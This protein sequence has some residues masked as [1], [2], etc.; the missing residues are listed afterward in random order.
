MYNRVSIK[1]P[2]IKWETKF[3]TGYKRIDDQHKE[4]VN[5][6]NDLYETGVVGDLSNEYVRRSF[7]AIIKRT[8]DYATYHF[9][10]E[11]KIMKAINYSIAR[12]HISKHRSFSIKVVEEVNKYENGDNLV[13]E[14]FIDFLKNWLI[15]HIIVEDKK[16]IYELK[17]SLKTICQDDSDNE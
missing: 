2:W 5:I 16:F 10:Y 6:I 4:L 12:D 7:N 13:I 9:S 11:E 15:N 8:I 17:T 1:K 14:D 3:Q